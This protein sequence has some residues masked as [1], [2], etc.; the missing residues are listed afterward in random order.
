MVNIETTQTDSFSEN[1]LSFIQGDISRITCD[2][3]IQRDAVLKSMDA[4]I[5][6]AETSQV[7][8]GKR[9]TTRLTNKEGILVEEIKDKKGNFSW[10]I[11]RRDLNDN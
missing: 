9:V 10:F 8:D 6:A 3:Q 7:N 11:Y 4:K 5:Q 2:N 1:L